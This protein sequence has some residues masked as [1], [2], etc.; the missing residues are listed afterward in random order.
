MYIVAIG[1]AYVILLLVLTAGSLA[2]ALAVFVF[3]GIVPI[4]LFVYAVGG[5]KTGR[6]S[7][8]VSNQ[9]TDQGDAS[10]PQGD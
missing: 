9:M 7:M 2:K 8:L 5:R 3:L 6:K 10:D 1:W 4:A